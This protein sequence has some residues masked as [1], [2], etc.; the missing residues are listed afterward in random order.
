MELLAELDVDTAEAGAARR[1]R[2]AFQ[3]GVCVL[4]RGER[5]GGW[6][7]AEFVEGGLAGEV[8]L[9]GDIELKRVDDS[10]RGGGN[11]G[12][13]TVARNER[14]V[15][16]HDGRQMCPPG[17]KWYKRSVARRQPL[18]PVWPRVER[19]MKVS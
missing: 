19:F 8:C 17:M 11:F 9:P 4:N 5:F 16:G 7:T 6:G 15:V 12:A 13:D 1:G 14:D 2:G 3:C 10:L 18:L